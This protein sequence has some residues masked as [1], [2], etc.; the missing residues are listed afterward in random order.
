MFILRK[1]ID[2]QAHRDGFIQNYGRYVSVLPKAVLCVL[3]FVWNLYS[4]SI[5]IVCWLRYNLF[6]LFFFLTVCTHGQ[7]VVQ[8]RQSLS[9]CLSVRLHA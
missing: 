7:S 4:E 5:G 8:G 6:R 3:Q 2:F 9:F 1:L